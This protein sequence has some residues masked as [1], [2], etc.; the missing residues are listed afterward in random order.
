MTKIYWTDTQAARLKALGLDAGALAQGFHTPAQRNKAFQAIEKKQVK[1]LHA[2]L[3]ER[4]TCRRPTRAFQLARDLDGLLQA[5]GFAKVSTPTITTRTALAKMG[6]DDTHPLNEQIFWITDT[7]CLRPMLAPGL[8][9]LMQ[10]FSRLD[11]RPVRFYEIGSCFRKE[12]EGACHSNEFTMLNLVEMGTAEA[13]R[14][15]RLKELAGMVAGTARVTDIRFEQESSA[16][17]GTTL[18]LVAHPFGLE[19]GSGAM[20]PHVL[21]TAWNITDTWVGMGFGMERLLMAS[22]NDTTMGRW[23][24]SLSYL[25]GIPLR[26]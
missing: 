14:L 23:A 10:D 9:S 5:Q 24:K 26:I 15:A 18:D 17:Y 16:V 4:L 7:Q 11:F 20:G 13:E 19:L 2:E 1:T 12:S 25:D 21:D 22:A 8:Y 3:A 6:I